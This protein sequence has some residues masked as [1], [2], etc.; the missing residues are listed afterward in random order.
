MY[1][2]HFI[3]EGCF[4][5]FSATFRTQKKT[6]AFSSLSPSPLL[7]QN[8][9]IRIM[10]FILFPSLWVKVILNILGLSNIGNGIPIIILVDLWNLYVTD[11]DTTILVIQPIRIHQFF[12]VAYNIHQKTVIDIVCRNRLLS[13]TSYYFFVFCHIFVLL[14]A[15]EYEK[16]AT[17]FRYTRF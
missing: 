17:R 12:Y 6:Q 8:V 10:L 4:Y 9:I 5:L 13:N 14:L 1:T 7:Y 16:S 2:Y 11:L 3:Y 15:D